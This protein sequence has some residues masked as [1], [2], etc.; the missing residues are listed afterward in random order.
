MKIQ[1]MINSG[2]IARAVSLVR[3]DSSSNQVI[4]TIH[5]SA[6]QF[7]YNETTYTLTWMLNGGQILPAGRYEVQLDHSKFIDMANNQL[8]GNG[9]AVAWLGLPVFNAAVNVQSQGSDIHATAYSVPLMA[10]WNADGVADLIV[11][12]Q[13]PAGVGKIRVYL[14]T[15]TA[16]APAFGSPFSY[17]QAGGSDLSV[18]SEGCLGVFPRVFDWNADGEKD[19]VLG[20]ADG[21]IEVFENTGS[22]ASPS[23]RVQGD[24]GY[25]RLE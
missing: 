19:L 11:G 3:L 9:E 12:E 1:A 24:T 25:G 7:S 4:D 2:T 15:G 14:N 22:T 16:D 18:S 13:T 23:F 10:D 8:Q 20:L 21:T 5:L 17:V 6:D